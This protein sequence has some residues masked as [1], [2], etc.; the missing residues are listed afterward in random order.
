MQGLE[1]GLEKG[2]EYGMSTYI[3]SPLAARAWNPERV[4]GV[5]AA[6]LVENESTS[7]SPRKS[8][9]RSRSRLTAAGLWGNPSGNE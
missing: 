2:D 7:R 6:R 1:K 5:A 4:A 3:A 9:R 8:C